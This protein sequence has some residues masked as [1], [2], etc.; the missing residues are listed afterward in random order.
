MRL[1][2][3]ERSNERH[4]PADY[5]GD[6][7]LWDIDKTYLDTRFSS[8]RGL[9][10]I[11]FEFAMDK[12]SI[13]GAIPLIRALRRGAGERPAMV[14]LFFVS[15]S[16]PQL[17]RVI[18][19]KMTLDGVDFDGITFKDQLGLLRAGRVRQIKAQLG[20]KLRALLLYRREIPGGGRWWMFGDDVEADAEVFA[21]FGAVCGG[22]ASD[23]L[24]RRLK[25]G[26]VPADERRAIHALVSELTIR[27]DPIERIFIHLSSGAEPTRFDDPRIVAVRSYLQAVLVLADLGRVQPDAVGA[28]AREMRGRHVPEASI[29]NDLED[30]SA[31]LAVPASL[32]E[33]AAPIDLRRATPHLA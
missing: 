27:V 33:L 4:L 15:G 17:R 7:L 1:P 11:P 24:E 26:H 29:A 12:E 9:L 21:T 28:V 8:W 23:H 6:V 16:P 5:R 25:A 31:R 14:P 32:I 19:R 13:P 10:A 18:E 22:M 30:A 20:Y 3:L 2:F